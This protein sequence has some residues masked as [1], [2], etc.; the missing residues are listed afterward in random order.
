MMRLDKM[1]AHCGYG[2]R[3]EVKEYIRKGYILVNGE[4][5]TNDDYKVDEI[6]DEIT[7]ADENVN[8]ENMIYLMLNKP[9]GYVSATFDYNDPTVIDLIDGYKNRNIFPV[10][11]LDKDTVGLLIITN[12]GQMAHKLLSPKSHVDKTY[13]LRY[14]GTITK[15]AISMFESGITIDD[16]YTCMP[17]KLIDLGN[18]EANVIIKEG[19]FHQVK[20]MMEAI[21]CEVVYLQRIKFGPISLDST[22]SEGEYRALTKEEIEALSI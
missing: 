14:T 2:S 19:K 15:D 6:N 12:D 3:K 17:A 18:N 7:F 4:I 10:G 1:L 21:G 22:L 20:R 8:Y 13:Y 5:V 9:D 16:G 11:R